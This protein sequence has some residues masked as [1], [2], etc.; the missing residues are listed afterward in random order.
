MKKNS[1]RAKNVKKINV[2]KLKEQV[3]NKNIVFGIDVAK[4]DM[5]AVFMDESREVIMTIKWKHPSESECVLELLQSLNC[6]RLVAA[7]EPSGTYGD[8][9]R[10]QLKQIGIEVF[11]VAPK[12]SS[13]FNEIYDGVPSSH[14]AK[15][16]A[17]VARLHSDGFSRVWEE[18]SDLEKEL[19][20]DISI[21]EI[22][23][24]HYRRQLNRLEALLARHW[25]ELTHILELTSVSLLELLLEFGGPQQ[26]SAAQEKAGK[27]LRRIGRHF[28]AQ[29]KIDAILKS[30]ATTLGVPPTE[31]EQQLI[32]HLAR[33]AR[34]ADKKAK[35]AKQKI[36]KRS[37]EIECITQMGKI[38]GKVTATVVYAKVGAPKD[39]TSPAMFIKAMGLNIKERSS[40]KH[41]GQLK[42]TKR[43]PSIVRK[44]LYMAILRLKQD[45]IIF[46]KWFERKIKR[47][48]GKKGRGLVALMRKIAKALWYVGQGSPF[49]ARLLFD[50]RRLKLTEEE[51]RGY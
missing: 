32:I 33:E 19:C 25:P 16:S 43:G 35:K 22:Y 42:I 15:S 24:E 40:G 12:K 8:S 13:N 49:D 46:E 23:Q 41:K 11:K 47:D 5:C 31:A 6:S 18:Q 45:N 34:R 2:K 26:V 27:L 7:M 21:L 37:E 9:F 48:G 30:A 51:I 4:E 10:F 3:T 29:E 50:C 20:A 14:D 1:Y 38:V 36:E 28:L 44:Y 17:V 39:F